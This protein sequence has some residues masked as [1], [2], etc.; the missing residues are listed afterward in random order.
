MKGYTDLKIMTVL[1]GQII[2]DLLKVV[3]GW[4]LT[5][6]RHCSS[7]IAKID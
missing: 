1:A 2:G 6:L 5:V 4:F 7:F 3:T